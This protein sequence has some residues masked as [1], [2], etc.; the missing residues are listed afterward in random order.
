ML[1]TVL[2]LRFFCGKILKNRGVRAEDIMNCC[3]KCFDEIEIQEFIKSI[4]EIG[5][6]DFCGNENIDICEE[7]ELGMFIRRGFSRAYEHV[8]EFSGAMWDSEEG[9][10]IGG[11]GE[12]AGESVFDILYWTEMIFS[13]LHDS[14][15]AAK[16]LEHLIRES[17]P[18][19]WEKADGADDP[20]EDIYSPSFVTINDLYKSESTEEFYAWKKFKHTCKYYN[21][22]FDL[23][24]EHSSRMNLLNSLRGIFELKSETLDKNQKLFRAREIKQ[25]FTESENIHWYKELG[26]APAKYAANNR[27]SPSGISYTYLADNVQTTIQEIRAKNEDK[28]IL[29]EFRTKHELRVLDLS[30]EVMV[31]KLSIFDE[32]YSHNDNWLEEFILHFAEEISRPISNVEKDIE[33]I[34]TQVLAEF[35]RKLKFDGIKFESSLTK[36]T[37]N[38]VLFC[39]PN[40]NFSREHYSFDYF[41]YTDLELPYFNEWLLLEN[42]TENEVYQGTSLKLLNE[43]K[44]IEH[45][46]EFS[47]E[48]GSSSKKFAK[49]TEAIGYIKE[50]EEYLKSTYNVENINLERE[51]EEFIQNYPSKETGYIILVQEGFHFINLTIKRNLPFWENQQSKKLDFIDKEKERSF[52]GDNSP[53]I[54]EWGKFPFDD[55]DDKL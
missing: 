3:Y 53:S 23:G 43:Y 32:E 10:Y 7:E 49:Y 17:G 52:F 44:E 13:E 46:K 47:L 22:Y 37:F 41:D 9:K 36:G 2:T 4:G 55:W 29:G 16:L 19:E 33:Y 35:I 20:L 39:G 14:D 5:D 38:Y 34:A 6:C 42:V 54:I 30:K 15:S 8:E 27:M 26:P 11:T 12:E 28:I 25:T 48:A 18:D 51:I 1:K 50:L 24:N 45:S 31:P 40:P 21:R